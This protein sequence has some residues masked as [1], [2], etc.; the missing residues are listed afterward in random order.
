[1]TRQEIQAVLIVSLIIALRLLGVFLV[2]PIF[3]VNATEYPGATLP[4]VGV[5]FGIYALFQSFLQIPL[6]WA[7]DR[8]GR[9][10]VL[11]LGLFLFSLGS[12]ACGMAENITQLIFARALQGCGAVASI[13]MAALGDLTRPEVRAQAFTVNG[14]VVGVFYLIGLLGGPLLASAFGFHNL[15]YMLGVLGFAAML[16]A[17]LFFPTI[18]DASKQDEVRIGEVVRRFEIQ[19]LY[20]AAFVLSF[21]VNIFF[22]IYPLSWTD[23]GLERSQLWKVYLLVFLPIGLVVF[24]YVRRAEKQNK[25]SFAARMGWVLMALGVF[26]YVTG[27]AENWILYAAGGAFFFGYTLFQ[28][29]LPAFLTQRVPFKGRGAATGFYNLASFLGASAGGMLAGILYNLNSAS[30]L[31]MSLVLLIVWMFTGL[32]KPPD[33][34]ITS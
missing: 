30:P 20:I 32:P 34:D 2:I 1:M 33:S 8:F 3:S 25:L 12:I 22:F 15:F 16:V 10:P 11:L 27:G 6:G 21:V 7:S 31:V 28:S 9:R 23:A 29:L 26:I 24:P 14:I 18:A 5:A 19:R 4:L 17:G 13:A